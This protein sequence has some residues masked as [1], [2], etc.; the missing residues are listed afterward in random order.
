MVKGLSFTIH[1]P[2]SFI[3]YKD[4]YM[5]VVDFIIKASTMTQ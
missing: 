5:D 3:L 4:P 1:Y 2:L